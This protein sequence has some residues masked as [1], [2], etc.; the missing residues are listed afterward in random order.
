MI[1]RILGDNFYLAALRAELGE[2]AGSRKERTKSV[3]AISGRL[4]QELLDNK[5]WPADQ[6]GRLALL[7]WLL[8]GRNA[9]IL[10]FVKLRHRH[11]PPMP[12]PG[13]VRRSAMQL[14][15]SR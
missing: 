8:D 6:A 3:R 7:L 15:S 1:D 10:Q 11:E 12:P 13:V 2:I 5:R 14:R 9:E 4:R